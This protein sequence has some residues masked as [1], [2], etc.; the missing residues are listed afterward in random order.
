MKDLPLDVTLRKRTREFT[1][2]SVPNGLL[3]SHSTKSATWGMIVVLEGRLKYRILEPEI[4][5][6]ELDA[7]RPGIIEPTIRHEVEPLGDVR[8]YIQFYDQFVA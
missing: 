7:E 4:E 8:F 6:F 2:L 5:E 1:A 3:K